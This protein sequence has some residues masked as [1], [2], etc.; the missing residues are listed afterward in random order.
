M[1]GLW[2]KA[3]KAAVASLA[4]AAGLTI[5]CGAGLA[6]EDEAYWKPLFNGEN[7]DGWEKTGNA[8]WKVEDG[9]L[10]GRQG[11]NDAAGDL[12]TEKNYSDF[13]LRVK[14]K[15]QW[16]GN[17]GVWF[18]Y[19]SP[20][21]AYQADILEYKNP[22]CYTGTLYCPGKM[23]L[24]M[25]E[26]PDLVN[27]EGWNTIYVRCEGEHTIIKLNDKKV[28]DVHDATTDHGRIG[29]QVHAGEQFKDMAITVS[30]IKVRPLS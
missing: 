2:M 12:L 5:L 6:A 18:R 30:E 19:Q 8:S 10:V 27:R 4:I 20:K 7:L 25:N 3:Y 9:C 11:P 1:Y 17:S 26:D 23:F 13:E 29:F 28:A 14:F 22:V 16:P 24:A 15:M 21:K